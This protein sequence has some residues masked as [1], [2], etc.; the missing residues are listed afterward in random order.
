MELVIWFLF[1]FSPFRSYYH[2]MLLSMSLILPGISDLDLYN[3]SGVC[4]LWRHTG[5]LL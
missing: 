5:C 4:P 1:F 3:C 2:V